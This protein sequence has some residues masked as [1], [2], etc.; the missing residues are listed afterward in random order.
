MTAMS[1]KTFTTRI[2]KAA[3]A[4]GLPRIKGHAICIGATLEY[5]LRGLPFDI[6]KAKGWWNSDTFH[7][8]LHDH[9]RVLAPYR[10]KAPQDVHNQFIQIAV[11]PAH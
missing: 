3:V 2:L 7:K 5:L 4:A 6:V 10:Q 8:Y 9:A 11:P 1:K